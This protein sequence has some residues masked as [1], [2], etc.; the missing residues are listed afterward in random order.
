MRKKP[1]RQV[2]L[3]GKFKSNGFIPEFLTTFLLFLFCFLSLDFAFCIYQHLVLS[4]S[5][6]EMAAKRCSSSG[7]TLK[8]NAK[9]HHSRDR[10]QIPFPFP[11]NYR[12]PTLR[13]SQ[14]RKLHLAQGCVGAVQLC[15]KRHS[16]QILEI[17]LSAKSR[18]RG[19]KRILS[20]Q[21]PYFD[22]NWGSFCGHSW[23]GFRTWN[24]YA[25][26]S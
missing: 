23:L 8:P 1:H 25:R 22:A 21:M 15:G 16:S 24:V 7:T 12:K 17:R 10:S 6:L 11:A 4:L 13:N 5:V 19:E 2:S 20:H 9:Q 26:S 3:G 14:S 18:K